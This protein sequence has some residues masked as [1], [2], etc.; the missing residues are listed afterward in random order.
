M[1]ST[2]SRVVWPLQVLPFLE[3][4]PLKSIR[5]RLDRPECFAICFGLSTSK[6]WDGQ[7]H[8]RVSLRCQAACASSSCHSQFFCS[9]VISTRTC[10]Q[11]IPSRPPPCNSFHHSVSF[12]LSRRKITQDR[13]PLRHHRRQCNSPV[14][15]YFFLC[16]CTIIKTL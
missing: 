16:C 6:P 7:V 13:I 4:Q 14:S 2:F 5:E 1:L 9:C 8:R 15:Y 11:L 10:R 12:S 3:V